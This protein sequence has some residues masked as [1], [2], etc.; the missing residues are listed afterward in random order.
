MPKGM[1]VLENSRTAEW[2]HL[3]VIIMP[4]ELYLS[5]VLLEPGFMINITTI[6]LPY[7][8]FIC[9]FLKSEIPKDTCSMEATPLRT[10]RVSLA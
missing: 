10:E 7:S 9:F 6:C 2:G 5:C 1:A 4:F 8:T 3:E